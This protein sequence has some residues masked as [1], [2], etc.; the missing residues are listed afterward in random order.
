[1]CARELRTGRE[2]N[3]WGDQ[4]R[5]RSSAP[6]DVGPDSVFVAYAAA[7]EMGCFLK[8]GWRTPVNIIDLFAEHRVETNGRRLPFERPDSLLSALAL[9]GLAHMADGN[10]HAMREL[11]MGKR[12]L[13]EYSAD[14]RRATQA[15]CR[16]D[17]VALEA[18]LPKMAI[19]NLRFALWRGRYAT[20]VAKMQEAGIPID[21]PLFHWLVESWDDLRRDLIT[22]VDA[23]LGF[24]GTYQGI[25]RSYA[26]IDRWLE[27]IGLRDSWPRTPSGLPALD[28]EVLEEQEALHP[29][30]P[31]IHLFRELQATLNQMKI[32]DLAVGADGRHR[33]SLH[34]FRTI[35]GRNAPTGS[36]F[37]PAKW[38]RGLIRPP[39][40][41]GLAYLDFAA[42]EVAIAAALSHDA[43]L[44]EHYQSDDIYWR[45]AVAVGLDSRG[46]RKTVR[47][48]V[49][50]LFLA[51]G[52]GMGPPTLARRAGITMAEAKE[53]LALH[54]TMYPHFT[55]WRSEIVDAAYL[56]G[57]LRTSCGWRRI[58]CGD[59][60]TRRKGKAGIIDPRNEQ[61]GWGRGVPYTE[62]MNWP[63][64]SA[65][66][67]LMRIVC[68]AGT[69]AGID[70]IMPVHDGFLI[71]A[72]LDRLEHDIACFES[73]M[74]RGSEVITRGL[75]M[76][77]DVKRVA[78]PDRYMDDRGQAMWDR[79][80]ALREAKI[81][82]AVA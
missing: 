21:V 46:D 15:Y 48:L 23:R 40:G 17:V 30:K 42:E 69:E 14:E 78:F 62:L 71:L 44:A 74:K 13:T 55:R 80:M 51:I 61:R 34:P 7:A 29:D 43:R 9:R 45:F 20:A 24:V 41:F 32:T 31:A 3:L 37:G 18:L 26:L 56:H 66:A 16:E 36:I 82:K 50:V 70:L 4:L 64:Q 47:A 52:Y 35:T 5:H 53:L 39:P 65:G 22:D 12:S 73:Q 27:E 54:A 59:I 67:D 6:F 1:M 10:K 63:I 28:D 38:M 60:A 49:K 75:T 25:H 58:G 19:D 8:L 77:V 68:I 57:W 81:R 2:I 76:K 72:P 33:V 79:I 11:I